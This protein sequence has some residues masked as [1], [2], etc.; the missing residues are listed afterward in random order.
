MHKN[1]EVVVLHRA[2]GSAC[3]DVEDDKMNILCNILLKTGNGVEGKINS[4][5][6]IQLQV[7]LTRNFSLLLL[8]LLCKFLFLNQWTSDWWNLLEVTMD[9]IS[10]NFTRLGILEFLKNIYVYMIKPQI[11]LFPKNL[12]RAEGIKYRE[13]TDRGASVS[14]FKVVANY[15]SN[16]WQDQIPKYK[17]FNWKK[18]QWNVIRNTISHFFVAPKS[19]FSFL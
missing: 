15:S 13:I 10:N 18:T 6:S 2:W 11:T 17:V 14:R 16:H 3:K 4:K 8:E 12:I 19:F 9:V 7:N 5:I 1:K